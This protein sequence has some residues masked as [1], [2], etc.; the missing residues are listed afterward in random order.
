V[1]VLLGIGKIR[2]K[3]KGGLGLGLGLGLRLGLEVR[4]PNHVDL[5]PALCICGI[6][7][8]TSSCVRSCANVLFVHVCVHVC[9]RNVHVCTCVHVCM[10]A[11]LDN[12]CLCYA[13]FPNV[14]L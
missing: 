11:C 1:R 7:S 13:L 10:C 3:V 12:A 4:V 2:V 8:F 14:L 6:R 9:M 5:M